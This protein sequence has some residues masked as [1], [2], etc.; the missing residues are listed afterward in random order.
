[1]SNTV[2]VNSGLLEEIEDYNRYHEEYKSRANFV[3]DA[4]KRNFDRIH[5]YEN[6]SLLD[7][8]RQE[9]S[10]RGSS[11]DFEQQMAD[12]VFNKKQGITSKQ[13]NEIK[14]DTIGIR[15]DLSKLKKDLIEKSKK[16]KKHSA[17]L[18]K[19][20]KEFNKKYGTTT[21]LKEFLK[22]SEEINKS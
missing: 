17:M 3:N 2:K 15:N 5:E 18:E 13:Y 20:I 4:I 16:N 10:K 12:L 22:L 11:G 21:G 19:G 8:L 9:F 14:K 6:I 7:S 1:M